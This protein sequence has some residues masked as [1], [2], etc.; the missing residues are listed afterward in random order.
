MLF[1]SDKRRNDWEQGIFSVHDEKYG[2]LLADDMK[3]FSIDEEAAPIIQEIF[4]LADSGKKMTEITDYLNEQGYESYGSHLKR[5]AR[6]NKPQIS[7]V[8]TV[9]AVKTILHTTSYKGKGT[10]NLDGVTYEYDIPAIVTP[11]MYDGVQEK[12]AARHPKIRKKTVRMKNAFTG[13]IIDAE[14]GNNIVCSR[15]EDTGEPVFPE[16]S[17]RPERYVRYA[18]VMEAVK[19]ALDSERI[20]CD[21]AERFFGTYTCERYV[22]DLCDDLYN[23]GVEAFGRIVEVQR[24]NIPL[25]QSYERGE[26][27]KE[28]YDKRHQKI[29]D[30]IRIKTADL[31][32]LMEEEKL[33]RTKY[34]RNNPWMKLYGN[35]KVPRQLDGV[36]VRKYV[37]KIV[38]HDFREIEV[39]L[40]KQEW[41]IEPE[42]VTGGSRNGKKEQKEN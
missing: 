38:L 32:A 5:V 30:N 4:E 1:R 26:I 11:E 12:L 29:L 22:S 31:D 27:S 41:R 28:E 40:K 34:S 17:W 9:G 2:Y 16:R 8:W 6:K 42:N 20:A 21:T 25:F 35:I 19:M 18:D 33:L 3:S 14:T 23:K 7:A 24:G 37:E 10:R 39:R 13:R 36:T 15:L